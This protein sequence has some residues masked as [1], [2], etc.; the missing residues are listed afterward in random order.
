MVACCLQLIDRSDVH[1]LKS[2]VELDDSLI[3]LPLVSEVLHQLREVILE[4]TSSTLHMLLVNEQH[5]ELVLPV[6]PMLPVT[7]DTEQSGADATLLDTDERAFPV[8]V[9][10]GWC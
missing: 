7:I 10:A 9:F 1:L 8:A 2:L 6:K 5:F 4:A 3:Q